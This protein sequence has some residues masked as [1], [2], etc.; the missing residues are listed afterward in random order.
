VYGKVSVQTHSELERKEIKTL[1]YVGI[2]ISY[3]LSI[4]DTPKYYVLES[5]LKCISCKIEVENLM[6]IDHGICIPVNTLLPVFVFGVL[7]K[8]S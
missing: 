6:K 2:H 8:S 5:K 7:Y 1:C 3:S 4:K